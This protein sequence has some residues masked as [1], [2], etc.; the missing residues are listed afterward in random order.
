MVRVVGFEPTRPFGP[1]LL[2]L[3]RL[4]IPSHPHGTKGRTRTSNYRDFYQDDHWAAA[5]PLSNNFSVLLTLTSPTV[6]IVLC[7]GLNA[8]VSTVPPPSHTLQV[9]RLR[10]K[11]SIKLFAERFAGISPA[12]QCD[13]PLGVRPNSFLPHPTSSSSAP[14]CR[15]LVRPRGL[16]PPQISPQAPQACAATNYATDACSLFVVKRLSDVAP[17][18]YG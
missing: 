7:A 9:L 13:Y 17:T 15:G 12:H 3:G 14:R 10:D 2:R 16:E 18:P 4:P 8:G 5:L 1:Q 11:A 6:H